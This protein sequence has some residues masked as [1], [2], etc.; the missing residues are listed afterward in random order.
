M[1]PIQ[2]EQRAKIEE[3]ERQGFLS[4][5]NALTPTQ[6]SVFNLEIDDYLKRFP[7][8][9]IHFDASLVQ[10]V[11]VLPRT[12]AFDAAIENRLTLD[13]LRG[14]LGEEISFEEFSIMIR[15]PTTRTM[16]IKSWHRDITRDYE[17]RMEIQAISLIYYLTDVTETDHCFSIIPETH[18]RLM[19]YRPEDVVPGMERD[20][21]GPAG[22]AVLFHAR[23]LHSGKLKPTSRERRTLHLYYSR[24]GQARTSEWSDIPARLYQN[25][26]PTLPPRLY[27][28]WNL[29][30][31]F[32]GTG[33]K[34]KDLDPAMSAADMIREVQRRA[35]QRR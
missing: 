32:E 28:K 11:N 16:D 34:P 1:T 8:E 20:L 31:V 22:T 19:D 33:K 13:F 7:E 27:S 3:F 4:V 14:L 30:D 21:L 35:N 25:H 2:L 18:N 23:C 17:R 26:D 24:N 15:Y 5:P 10:T 6:I 29:T 9:W 12:S